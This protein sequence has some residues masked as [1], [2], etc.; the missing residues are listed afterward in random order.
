MF[1]KEIILEKKK[2]KEK[3]IVYLDSW[4]EQDPLPEDC[5]TALEKA[6]NKEAKD[7]TKSWKSS[8]ELTNFVF[9]DL[10]V[11][12]PTANLKARWSQY[13]TLL[14]VAIDNLKDSRGFSDW[15]ITP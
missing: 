9:S 6:I 7:L 5:V 15:T 8:I 14:K 10:K 11:P 1:L 2:E 3:K 4:D 13:L 12:Q